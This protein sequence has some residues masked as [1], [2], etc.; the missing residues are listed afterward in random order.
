VPFVTFEGI[1]GTGK[2]TAVAHVAEA[3][4]REGRDVVATREETPGPAG[5]LVHRS[6]REGWDPLAT[7]F[8]FVADRAAH[9]RELRPALEAGAMVLCDRFVHSTYAYQSV[10]L[11]G[12]LAEPMAFLRGL[13]DGWCPLP[14]RVVLLTC[15]PAKA[16]A[17]TEKRGAT[18][19]YEKVAFLAKV[20]ERYLEMARRDAGR[21]V[22]VDT[23]DRSPGDVGAEALSAVRGML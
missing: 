23:T 13:H 2:S 5:Q 22:V 9:V 15:D 11:E 19:P 21:F 18:T 7:T 12:R 14:D 16:V 3:L 6:I 8:L 20:Q 4:R 1:D 10:T 17:R